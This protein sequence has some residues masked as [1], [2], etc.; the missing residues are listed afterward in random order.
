[1]IKVMLAG[2]PNTGKSVFFNRLTGIGVI[3]SNYPGTT[4]EILRGKTRVDGLEVEVLDLPGT[5]S[6]GSETEDQQVAT[7]AML[8]EDGVI[9]DIVDAS[10]LKR[11]LYLTLQLIEMGKPLVVALNMMDEARKRGIV[12]DVAKL[13]SALGVP[14]VPAI[15]VRGK[16]V[17]EAIEEAIKVW[18]RKLPPARIEYSQHFEKLIKP[19]EEA[20]EE[21]KAALGLK[22]SPRGIAIKL[23]EGDMLVTK[24]ISE[25]APDVAEL[26][27][28]IQIEASRLGAS[29]TVWIAEERYKLI[30]RLLK[31]AMIE[32]PTGLALGEKLDAIVL[33]PIAGPIAL[34]LVLASAVLALIY[35][36]G[37]IEEL[38]VSAW[39]LLASP[40]LSWSRATLSP[41]VAAAIEGF[42]LGVE[43][44][45]AVAI[46][47]ILVFY[48]LLAILEDVGYLPR[49]AYLT[50]NLMHKLGLHGRAIIPLV[51]GYGC[52][53]P[54]ILAT[55]TLETRRE[56]IIAS[57]LSTMVP[58]SAR[59]AVIVGFLGSYYGIEAAIAVYLIDL[60]VVFTSGL[61]LN[62]LL[63][64]E[65]AGLV[66][67]LPP[68]RAPSPLPIISKTWL[69]FK[70]FM[71]TALPLLVAGSIALSLL[72]YY[73]L[74]GLFSAAVSPL[75]VGLLR[76]PRETAVPLLFGI[77]RKEMTLEM[78]V[79]AF[80]TS[81]L[82]A[83]MSFQQ[84][85]VFT[86]V[87]TLYVPCIA[88]I[89][90][91]IK[92][93]GL[94][95]AAIAILLNILLATLVGM[96]LAMGLNL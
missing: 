45:L 53:V 15:A 20:L 86:A 9:V 22:A 62:R 50:D 84:A 14:V 83:V 6:L 68:Y 37:L 77:L 61:L 72:D 76:L 92:E 63:K 32:A 19:I 8:E 95:E 21:K 64:G 66:M 35:A 47:Y 42:S 88:T 1:M 58:C 74:T 46:P 67:E 80:R 89:A 78:L 71:D 65:R 2:N 31:E 43:A 91:L 73:E 52:N 55:R 12:I 40:L 7:R 38:M 26:A 51:I 39:Q 49:V 33:S 70:S 59:T 34:I 82:S 10:R 41:L 85:L 25:K 90:V 23:L 11:N 57:F 27:R 93:I 5:Y 30:D 75:I 81:N 48:V 36:G 28:R 94:R 69:R 4:V 56:R 54:A 18:S 29:L 96:L 79:V 60:A 44:A 3:S 17:R 13:S 16:G 24:L 87:T